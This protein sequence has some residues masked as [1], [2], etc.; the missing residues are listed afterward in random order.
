MSKFVLRRIDAVQGNQ[1]F[2]ILIVNDDSPFD[3]FEKNLEA[4]T[5]Q[6]RK[7]T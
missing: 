1:T 5:Y 6:A 2:E 7:R 4:N 3:N